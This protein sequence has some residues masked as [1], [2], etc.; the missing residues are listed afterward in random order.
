MIEEVSKGIRKFLDEPHEKIYLNMI[1]IVIFSVIYYQ[2]YLNDQTS[3]MVNEQLLKEKDGKLD[4]VDFLYF[5]LLL[6][7][8]LSFGDM[9]PFTKEIKAVSSVQSLI[10]WAIAL[11]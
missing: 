5:S 1:L 2:L 9:V 3:F 6:Q 4:Y 8:T 11:Y 7:F 10:F